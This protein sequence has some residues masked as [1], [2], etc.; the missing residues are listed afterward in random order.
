MANI[1]SL[2]K[3]M[4]T[5]GLT[6]EEKILL[7]ETEE[8]EKLLSRQWEEQSKQHLKDKVNPEQMWTNIASICFGMPQKRRFR[9]LTFAYGVAAIVVLLVIGLWMVR[10]YSDSYVTVSA[11]NSSKMLVVTLPD[12]SKV[13]LNAGSTIRY[14]KKFRDNRKID[15]DGEA[16]FSVTKMPSSP[17]C[18][19]FHGATVEVKGTEF[20]VKSN[21]NNSEVTLFSGKVL[22]STP[23]SVSLEMKPLDQVVYNVASKQIQ[24]AHVDAAEYD[25]RSTEFRFSDKPLKELVEFLNRT[26]GVKITLKNETYGKMLFTG[27]IRKGETLA[28]VLDKVCISF[29]LHK[30]STV[31][32]IILY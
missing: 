29:D 22:F 3:K 13:W 30:Q 17:F 28:D 27:T 19:L 1:L 21:D 7:L 9:P 25:W 4:L 5:V 2:I 15:L 11:L 32:S 16:F 10:S 8:M 18:V 26:Y 6:C 12:H 31:D 24:L 20:N 23:E 14:P